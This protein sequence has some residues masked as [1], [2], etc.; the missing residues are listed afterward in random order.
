MKIYIMKDRGGMTEVFVS[1]CDTIRQVKDKA[2][3][4]YVDLRYQGGN[5]K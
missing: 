4:G 3:L 2:R 1:R 5:V